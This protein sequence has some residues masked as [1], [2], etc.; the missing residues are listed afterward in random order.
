MAIK[1]YSTTVDSHKTCGQVQALLAKKGAK[2]LQIMYHD[3]DPIGI[4]FSIVLND[5]EYWYRL[6]AEPDGVLMVM[7]TDR[8]VPKGLKN[9]QQATRVAWRIIHDWI[10]SQIAMI[11]SNKLMTMDRIFLPFLLTQNQKGET[12]TI[13]DQF[14]SGQK[15]LPSGQ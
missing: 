6:P 3:G 8:N 13:Y 1:N 2:Q 7:T 12:V 10:S 14:K 5:R 15:L 9:R 4:E 11:E